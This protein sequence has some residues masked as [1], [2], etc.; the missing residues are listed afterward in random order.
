MHVVRVAE[1]GT[2][3]T[4]FAHRE[5]VFRGARDEASVEPKNESNASSN[6][7]DDSIFDRC[8]ASNSINCE[9][10]MRC[11]R[12]RPSA[13]GVATSCVP[14]MIRVGVLIRAIAS[15]RSVSRRA[16]QQQK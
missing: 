1:R 8:A 10:A 14:L 16:A 3:G 6:S 5:E 13:G 12:K 4:I 11:A 7:C 9:S 2:N 15:R